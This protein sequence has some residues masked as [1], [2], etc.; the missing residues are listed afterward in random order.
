MRYEIKKIT[1]MLNELSTF[2]LEHDADDVSIRIK[3]TEEKITIIVEAVGITNMEETIK[4]LKDF[5]SYPRELEMEEYYW[6]LAGEM[7]R[8]EELGLIGA[9]VD[10]AKID[11]KDDHIY[12]EL[13]RFKKQG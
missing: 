7:Q 9:M 2:C 3:R 11:Y 13:L 6:E 4:N 10:E 12:I 8:H 1:K 5:L